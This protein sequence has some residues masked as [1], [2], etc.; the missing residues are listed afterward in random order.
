MTRRQ[1]GYGSGGRMKIEKDAVEFYSGI[2]YGKTIG[3]PIGLI[4]QNLDAKNW[5]DVIGG[6]CTPATYIYLV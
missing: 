3:S 6:I 4:I 2:R 5:V 1:K